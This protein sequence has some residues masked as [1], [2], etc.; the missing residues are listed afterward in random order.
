MK[1]GE[2]K[3]RKELKIQ[4]DC[5]KLVNYTRAS[6]WC[7]VKKKKKEELA[8]QEIHNQFKDQMEV[9][10]LQGGFS[11]AFRHSLDDARNEEQGEEGSNETYCM[12]HQNN[13]LWQLGRKL[14]VLMGL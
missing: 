9:L 14:G 13:G 2:K 5:A 10:F 6:G 7:G 8:G 12:C 1:V 4:Q 3:R 11:R